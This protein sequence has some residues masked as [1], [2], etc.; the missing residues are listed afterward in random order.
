M[1][2]LSFL[3]L[4]GLQLEKMCRTRG[5]RCS[6]AHV[7]ATKQPGSLS[8]YGLRL[9]LSLEDARKEWLID[10]LASS[11]EAARIEAA[12]RPSSSWCMRRS[13]SKRLFGSLE[14]SSAGAASH[15]GSQQAVKAKGEGTQWG[16]AVRNGTSS[17]RIGLKM[18]L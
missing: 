18:W 16:D 2:T 14:A 15:R 11:L 10:R 5:L 12:R 6:T 7:E 13:R 4:A 8:R 1:Y 9:R 17:I 3:L